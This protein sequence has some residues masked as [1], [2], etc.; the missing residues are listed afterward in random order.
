MKAA[1]KIMILILTFPFSQNV[2]IMQNNAK[3]AVLTY[4]TYLTKEK[5]NLTSY[6]L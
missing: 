6:P 4:K 5:N 2:N 3:T 1:R